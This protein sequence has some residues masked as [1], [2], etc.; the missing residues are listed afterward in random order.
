VLLDQSHEEVLIEHLA[1]RGVDSGNDAR[2]TAVH[3]DVHLVVQGQGHLLA[4]YQPSI[5]IG[6]THGQGIRAAR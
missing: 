6:A 2:A 1:G 5:R 3:A 4:S